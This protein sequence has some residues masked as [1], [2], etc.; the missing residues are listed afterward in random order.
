MW[1]CVG[2]WGVEPDD[3]FSNDLCIVLEI[4]NHAFVRCHQLVGDL[5]DS[6]V[7]NLG[8][9]DF[10]GLLQLRNGFDQDCGSSHIS[11]AEWPVL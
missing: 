7:V 4:H 9:Q 3:H 10:V 8:R 5:E 1:F 2:W 11:D 6:D